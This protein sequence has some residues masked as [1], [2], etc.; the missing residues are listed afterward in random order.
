MK[1]V[2]AS[3][4]LIFGIAGNAQAY[5]EC[6]LT[7]ASIYAGDNGAI[8]ATSAENTTFMIRPEDPN[9]KNALTLMTAALM[10]GNKV[11]VRFSS[12][13]ECGGGV[14]YDFAGIWLLKK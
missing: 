2:I 1:R 12:A 5:V 14:K 7:L 6:P 11:S 8:W 13:T 3:L 10:G 9:L 4:G